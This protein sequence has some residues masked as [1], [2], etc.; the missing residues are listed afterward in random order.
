MV[1]LPTIEHDSDAPGSY[2]VTV[3]GPRYWTKRRMQALELLLE[4]HSCAEVGRRIGR[5]REWVSLTKGAPV[6]KAKLDSMLADELERVTERGFGNKTNRLVSMDYATRELD[7]RIRAGV[8]ITERRYDK[9]GN[10]VTEVERI[11][12]DLLAEARQYHAALATELGQLPR[13]GDTG[14]SN[15]VLIREVNVHIER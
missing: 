10:L 3:T 8:T 2:D 14:V 15:L 12:K 9:D 11:D 6:F 4:G 5:S 1:S 7:S 13:A